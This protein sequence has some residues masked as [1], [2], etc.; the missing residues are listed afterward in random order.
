MES[1][2]P[3]EIIHVE[4][5]VHGVKCGEAWEQLDDKEKLYSYYFYRACWEG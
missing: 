3:K 5:P 2:T 4:S 1:H